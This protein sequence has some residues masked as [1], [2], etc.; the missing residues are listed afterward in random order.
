MISEERRHY[1]LSKHLDLILE[2]KIE[3]ITPEVNPS[4]GFTVIINNNSDERVEFDRFAY[5]VLF[6]FPLEG[7]ETDEFQ[8]VGKGHSIFKGIVEPREKK[9][10]KL[11]FE[12][13]HSKVIAICKAMREARNVEGQIQLETYFNRCPI[14]FPFILER[15]GVPTSMESWKFIEDFSPTGWVVKTFDFLIPLDAWENFVDKVRQSI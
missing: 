11:A 3:L 10:C 4:I 1:D 7:Q 14:V 8:P 9:R 12:I 6:N 15:V 13:S 2:P 5:W